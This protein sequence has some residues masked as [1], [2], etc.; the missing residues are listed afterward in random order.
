MDSVRVSAATASL[1]GLTGWDVD[2][3][4][5]T[6]YFMLGERC[7]GQCS[8][9]TQGGDSLSRVRWPR[10]SLDE[11]AS[12]LPADVERICLQT[13]LYPG[14]TDDVVTT[15]ASLGGGIP[16]S[17]SMNPAGPETLEKLRAAGVDRIGIGL[18]CCTRELFNRLK[19]HVPSWNQYLQGLVDARDVFGAA[20][21]HLIVGLGESDREAI[22]MMQ[23]LTRRDIKVALFAHH[24]VHGGTAPPVER[25]RYLQFVRYRMEQGGH[26]G[27]AAVS[28]STEDVAAAVRTSGCPG[29]NRPFYNERV[30]GPLYNYPRPLTEAEQNRAVKEVHAYA[31]QGS[32]SQ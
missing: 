23:W 26:G 24:P 15:V 10:F 2:V 20:T 5:T 21:A 16:V 30:R 1:L 22:E 8:Y 13:R 11:V 28:T 27:D 9:C 25:Y 3:A 18:D 7:H 14:V 31:R 12:R 32:A 6:L 29:C 4:P 17:V 19:H